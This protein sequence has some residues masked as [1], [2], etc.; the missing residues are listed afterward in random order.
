MQI[1]RILWQNR[2]DFKAIYECEHCGHE[3]ERGGYDDNYYHQKV[4]PAMKCPK[5][6]KTT[7]DDY[8]PHTTKYPDGTVI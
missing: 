5:C 3:V 1:K 2:R 8:K 4:I 7:T 6:G